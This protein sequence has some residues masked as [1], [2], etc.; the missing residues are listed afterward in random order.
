MLD[1][2]YEFLQKNEVNLFS[3]EKLFTFK[4]ANCDV[5]GKC[6]R[7]DVNELGEIKII[8]YKT[9]KR[10]KTEKELK[11]DIQM[12]IY[13]MYAQLEKNESNESK[14]LGKVPKELSQLFLRHENPEVTINFTNEEL[15]QFREK[16][17]AIAHKIRKG[18]FH[19]QKG[20]HCQFC[21]YRDLV[22]P[23]FD[24]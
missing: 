24:E 10:Q 8:D 19:P 18:D 14:K 12:A 15:A 2:Y 6:D 9:S 13:A 11:K 20:N 23:L 5:S 17:E 16:I 7:I 1:N 21:D 4:L 22:C 3:S